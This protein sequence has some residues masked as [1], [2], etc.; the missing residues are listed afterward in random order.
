MKSTALALFLIAAF[1]AFAQTETVVANAFPDCLVIKDGLRQYGYATGTIGGESVIAAAYSNGEFGA[2]TILTPAG[3]PI[4]TFAP[5]NF[6]GI[7]PE[8]ALT[9]IDGDG[10]SEIVVTMNQPR[11][12]PATWIYRFAN[13]KL[14]PLGPFRSGAELPETDLADVQF[15][16]ID[17]TN[18]LSLL[19]R[20]TA[21]WWDDDGTENTTETQVLY[22]WSGAGFGSGQPVDLVSTAQR[23]TAAPQASVT[24]FVVSA[25]PATRTLLLINGDTGGGNRASSVSVL[26]NNHEVIG[27]KDLNQTIASVRV[28]VT[29]NQ[30]TNQVAIT[31]K[32]GPGAHVTVLVLP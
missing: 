10:Q 9:D 4:A 16:R 29:L 15:L 26:L 20:H 7:R 23:D 22:T 13:D 24:S 8:V 2:V 14:T 11:G 28:P 12:L 25:V 18:R 19:D 21:R 6:V 30:L 3:S 17:G 31:V 27:E 1:G 5:D 32:S